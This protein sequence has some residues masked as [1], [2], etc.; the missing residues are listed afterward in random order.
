MC[1]VA[2]ASDLTVNLSEMRFIDVAGC[3]ALSLGTESF[4]RS[5]QA[6]FLQG[7]RPH[8]HKVMT[9]LGLDRLD[10][11]RLDEDRDVD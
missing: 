8:V 3:R 2:A 6:V 5:G 7:L 10:N 4:R 9:L 1:E 11:V